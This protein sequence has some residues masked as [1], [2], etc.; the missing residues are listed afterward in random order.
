M[1]PHP[2]PSRVQS[3]FVSCDWGTSR[4][5][6][7]LVEGADLLVTASLESADGIAATFARWSEVQ[8][9]GGSRDAFY[10][11]VLLGRIAELERLRGV[12]L[13]G[14]PLVISGMAS[15]SIGMAD[16]PY[17]TIPFAIDGSDL[18]TRIFQASQEFTHDILMISG[19]RDAND[20]MRGEEVQLVGA[21]F[22]AP[23][24]AGKRLLVFPGTHSKHVVVEGA[25]ATTVRTYMTGELFDLLVNRSVLGSSVD[26]RGSLD[27]AARQRAF[28]EG[29]RVGMAENFLHALFSVRVRGVLQQ[30]RNPEN[31][32]YLSGLVLGAELKDLAP[33]DAAPLL[34]VASAEAAARYRS[35][36]AA[37]GFRGQIIEE[38]V[39]KALVTGQARIAE[40]VGMLELKR[41]AAA[42]NV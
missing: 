40:R 8:E 30:A 7:R 3:R 36:M 13:T 17:K 19:V 42:L 15:S 12:R 2:L 23:P 9:R 41:G 28:E 22:N 35:A 1:I 21:L 31:F 27:P 4:L 24:V 34:I 26:G 29:V 14:I 10:R 39:E 5:R 38:S 18:Q 25:R 20:L 32:H 11:S 16:L 37:V 33:R 6:L